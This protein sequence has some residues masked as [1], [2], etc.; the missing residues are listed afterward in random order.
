[1][2]IATTPAAQATTVAVAEIH[3]AKEN[4]RLERL[5]ERHR[6]RPRLRAGSRTSA[7]SAALAD[8]TSTNVL[9]PAAVAGRLV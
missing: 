1:M 6:R 8:V 2:A 4:V 7:V 5:E 3:V 9:R